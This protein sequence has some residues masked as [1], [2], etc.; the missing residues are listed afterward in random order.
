MI[1]GIL[2]RD[3]V[4]GAALGRDSYLETRNEEEKK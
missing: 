1:C 2:A 3:L 4:V